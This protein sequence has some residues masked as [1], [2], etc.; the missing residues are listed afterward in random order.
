MSTPLTTD[1]VERTIQASPE[2]VYDI[3]ADVTRMPELSPEILSC[4]WLDGATGPAPGAR[5]RA[6]NTLG[7]V[8]RW[9]NRPVVVTAERGREFTVSRTEPLFGTLEWSFRLSPEG[10]GTRVVE[11]YT[12][13]RPLSPLAYVLLRLMGQ[14]ERARNLRAG[15]ET[16]LERLAV[17]AQEPVG[18]GTD[19]AA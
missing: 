3:V 14:K 6:V 2:A 18:T 17:V 16:T 5:F 10:A 9:P 1:A 12:V 8:M 15:M 4:T 19:A 13:T 7:G 11:S